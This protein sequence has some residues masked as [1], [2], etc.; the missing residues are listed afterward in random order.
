M[1]LELDPPNIQ[2]AV[3]KKVPQ[4]Q[5]VVGSRPGFATTDSSG[6]A[7]EFTR[8]KIENMRL[9]KA[10][11]FVVLASALLAG[12]C[13]ETTITDENKACTNTTTYSNEPSDP[14]EQP[15]GVGGGMT[16]VMM[17]KETVTIAGIKIRF[18]AS[19]NNTL[20]VSVFRGHNGGLLPPDPSPEYTFNSVQAPTSGFDG[21]NRVIDLPV[22]FV[23]APLD[24]YHEWAIAVT[25][26]SGS[27]ISIYDGYLEEWAHIEPYYSRSYDGTS[28]TSS[29]NTAAVG[30]KLASDCP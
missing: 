28:W 10:K 16:F 4:G 2:F 8:A 5:S 3:D 11:L 23:A 9:R 13:T 12:S 19:G 21:E 1:V 25:V 26:V 29:A 18:R 14:H 22:P 27:G 24:E 17:R 15:L 20:K 6:I 30:L 7:R